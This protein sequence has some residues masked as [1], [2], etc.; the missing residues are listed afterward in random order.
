MG[1]EQILSLRSQRSEKVEAYRHK[2]EYGS[3]L[4]EGCCMVVRTLLWNVEDLLMDWIST[5]SMN[6]P[7]LATGSTGPSTG[8]RLVFCSS[9][10]TRHD[11]KQH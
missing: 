3:P 1:R 4:L 2:W 7:S 9:N 5:C 11:K 8:R 6:Y 10:I